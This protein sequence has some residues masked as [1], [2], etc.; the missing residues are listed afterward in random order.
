[1]SEGARG[2]KV[3]LAGAVTLLVVVDG[4]VVDGAL[5]VVDEVGDDGVDVVVDDPLDEVGDE[6]AS[7]LGAVLAATF[8]EPRIVS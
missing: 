7:V 4:D 8:A 5:D 6:G 1:V 3:V 2:R